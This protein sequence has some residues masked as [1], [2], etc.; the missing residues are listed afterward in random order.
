MVIFLRSVSSNKENHLGRNFSRCAELEAHT[1]LNIPTKTIS[2]VADV[3]KII[4][5]WHKS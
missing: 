5:A 1:M 4:K 2:E 3:V